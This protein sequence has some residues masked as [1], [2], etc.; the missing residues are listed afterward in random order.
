MKKLILIALL[1][2][3]LT[4]CWNQKIIDELGF[5]LQVGIESG[6]NEDIEIT[7]NSPLVR[8]NKETIAHV[9]STTE[10]STRIAREH[11]SQ[12]TPDIFV[13]GKIQQLLFS[14]ELAQKG[15]VVYLDSF[16]KD[17]IFPLIAYIV[18]VDGSPKELITNMTN[19]E[20]ISLPSLYM[21]DLIEGNVSSSSTV[22]SKLFSFI[23]DYYAEGVDPITPLVKM[24]NGDIQIMG[25]A[26]FLNDQMVGK[27]DPRQTSLLLAALNQA[28]PTEYEFHTLNPMKETSNKNLCVTASLIPKKAKI[29]IT[30]VHAEPE[31]DIFLN[32]R[33]WITGYPF[34]SI[35]DPKIQ[36][37]LKEGMA[38]EIE[39]DF[40]EMISIVQNSGS[41][42]LGIGSKVHGKY[43]EYWN[44]ID[45][46]EVYPE[47]SINVHVNLEISDAGR[48]R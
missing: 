41:D 45:W 23:R 36:D 11:F 15:I 7:I 42:P 9:Q 1:T 28:K 22:E 48:L 3:T 46:L 6:E 21:N 10:T 8:P 24:T 14:E 33:S 26:L 25:S 34:G 5:I 27:I 30:M 47:I 18:V 12:K 43:N 16:Q 20:M 2:L 17:P 38:R 44:S 13:N 40:M 31:V 29:N 4:G 37:E 32:F 35:D 19:S 39:K